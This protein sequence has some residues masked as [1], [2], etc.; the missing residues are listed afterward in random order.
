MER[1]NWQTEFKAALKSKSDFEEFFNINFPETSYPFFLPKFFAHKIKTA[2]ENS[3]LWNQFIPSI[4]EE[5]DNGL[6]DPIG[7]QRFQVTKNLIHRY[8]NRA[9]FI[10]TTACPV[11]CRYCFRKNELY[12]HDTFKQEMSATLNYLNQ[13]PEIEE[14]IFTG[15]DPLIL[16]DEKIHSYLEA[17]KNISSVKIIR[18][19]TRTPVIIPSRI[20]DDF[21]SMLGPFKNYFDQ[22]VFMVHINHID[23]TSVE[24]Q[25]ALAKL[26]NNRYML[27]SQ[28]VLLKDVNSRPQDLIDLF[29]W[30][31]KNHVIPYYLHHPDKAKGSGHFYLSLETGRKIYSEL[32]RKLPG[33][34]I[35]QY[36]FDIPGGE[37]K[38]PAFNPENFEFQG[39]LI[40]SRSEIVHYY[41]NFGSF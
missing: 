29:K 34:L 41:E 13:H 12:D 16:S 5:T 7:D 22:I 11:I 14:I 17:F 8:D 33:W 1:N 25:D 2:G 27:F 23:E 40:N 3:P 31:G 36:I 9:L 32:R 6:I 35:P 28:S 19:H 38:V 26:S 15:G 39:K 18:F 30:L 21:L 24:L 4:K 10:P 37:G 20:D